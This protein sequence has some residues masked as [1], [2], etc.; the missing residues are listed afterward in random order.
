MPTPTILAKK[1]P[2]AGGSGEPGAGPSPSASPLH[3]SAMAPPGEA[4]LRHAS[5]KATEPMS[6]SG[7]LINEYLGFSYDSAFKLLTDQSD[8]AVVGVLGKQGVGK[9]TIMS[10]LCGLFSREDP[11][12]TPPFA[13][14]SQ[15]TALR[16]GHETVGVDMCVSP[17][18]VIVLD[19]QPVLS[20]SILFQMLDG[21]YPLPADVSSHENLQELQ[22]L[23]LAVLLFSI[24]H[25]VVVAHDWAADVDLWKFVRSVEMLKY[26]IPDVAAHM[27]TLPDDHTEQNEYYPDIVFVFNKQPDESFAEPS[28][29]SLRQSLQRFFAHSKCKCKS[30]S[31]TTT[32]TTTGSGEAEE[33]PAFFLLPVNEDLTD[34]S[35]Q[36]IHSESYEVAL[37]RFRSHVLSMPKRSFSRPLTEREWLK[38][39]GRIWELIKKSPFLSDY[40]RTLNKMGLYQKT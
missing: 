33:G 17:D 34:A 31:T 38:N 3:S 22:S 27:A 2:S 15:E 16:C 37:E 6:A 25:V 36:H 20:P 5:G 13:T 35:V 14:Q 9:S 28:L 1:E 29:S 24:C 23:Q 39:T 26:R 19:T 30:T 12:A 10:D 21:D 4:G 18:R 32:T 8:F 40:S 7:K 11:E